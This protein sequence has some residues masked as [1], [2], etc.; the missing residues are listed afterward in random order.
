VFV[1]TPLAEMELGLPR[2]VAG[3]PWRFSGSVEFHLDTGAQAAQ[4]ND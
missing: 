2:G 3:W 4:G 1:E